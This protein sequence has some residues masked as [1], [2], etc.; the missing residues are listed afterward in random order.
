M[1]LQ[2]ARKLI[3]ISRIAMG[4]LIFTL[5]ST[6]VSSTPTSNH[7]L[8]IDLAP[9]KNGTTAPNKN[10][11]FNLTKLSHTTSKP[12]DPASNPNK[13]TA[14]NFTPAS[15]KTTIPGPQRPIQPVTC[16]KP[17]SITPD[18]GFGIKYPWNSTIKSD[19]PGSTF[20]FLCDA[21]FHLVPNQPLRKCQE[22]GTW[23]GVPLKCVPDA[24]AR[25]PYPDLPEH[26]FAKNPMKEFPI[27]SVLHMDCD[28]GWV[29]RGN[30]TVQCN[31][32]KKW[33]VDFSCKLDCPIHDLPDNSQ[34]SSD[35]AYHNL[36]ANETATVV[37]KSGYHLLG[38]PEVACDSSG[39]L[40][41]QFGCCPEQQNYEFMKNIYH[42]NPEYFYGPII[43]LMVVVNISLVLKILQQKKMENKVISTDVINVKP[44]KRMDWETQ[45]APGTKVTKARAGKDMQL[46]VQKG[47]VRNP[48]AHELS[49]YRKISKE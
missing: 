46:H 4:I 18:Y 49:P 21:D 14:S 43:K 28:E 23:S 42:R 5:C 3:V 26:S 27:F 19:S 32:K 2:V 15:N 9:P 25:C 29:G 6:A 22:N 17:V 34:L 24:S 47:A 31:H 38:V 10:G 33:V 12:P 16:P 8:R 37:C 45:I 11:T 41:V 35:Y 44:A 7:T 48:V 30:F 36:V 40:K 13:T 1:K 20:K 39:H